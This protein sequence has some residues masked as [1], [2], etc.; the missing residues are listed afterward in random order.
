[1]A[2]VL[3]KKSCE[4]FNPSQGFALKPKP[5]LGCHTRARFEG[6]N[7]SFIICKYV[8]IALKEYKYLIR[9]YSPAYLKPK[10]RLGLALS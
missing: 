9:V 3:N 4:G 5:R 1:M 6:E 10:P 7:A 8:N 2:V